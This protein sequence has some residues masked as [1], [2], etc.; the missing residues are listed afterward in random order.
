MDKQADLRK[1]FKEKW[2]DISRKKKGGGHPECGR[3]DANSGGGYPKCRPAR[4]AARMSKKQK[5]YAVRAK[6]SKP[7]G[8]GGKPTMVATF[9]KKAMF[10][11][12][13]DSILESLEV[14]QKEAKEKQLTMFDETKD[15][16]MTR[17][18]K[19]FDKHPGKAALI[20]GGTAGALY[21]LK[22]RRDRKK[23][24]AAEQ[25]GMQKQAFKNP[26]VYDIL[27][28]LDKEA[29]LGRFKGAL[30]GA[31]GRKAYLR[32]VRA[33]AAAGAAGT[34]RRATAQAS[35]EA[36]RAATKAAIP[37]SGV[38]TPVRT[39]RRTAREASALRR[40]R[41]TPDAAAARR[42]SGGRSAAQT[43]TS[44]ATPAAPQASSAPTPRPQPQS[45]TASS[46]PTAVSGVST[47]S[48]PK[49]KAQQVAPTTPKTPAAPKGD[50]PKKPNY[51]NVAKGVAGEAM[52]YAKAK[53]IR[54]AIGVGTALG[55]AN[56]MRRPQT[57][58]QT[59]QPTSSAAGRAVRGA[60]LGAGAV[61]GGSKLLKKVAQDTETIL[62]TLEKEAGRK[63]SAGLAALGAPVGATIGA[64]KGL[65]LGPAGFLG[66]MYAG[67]AAAAGLGAYLGHGR[68]RKHV[69]KTQTNDSGKAKKKK[70]S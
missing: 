19:M 55:A 13:I 25:A 18:G 57:N 41:N 64:I 31:G 8:V 10:N 12:E 61:Y 46:K 58:P 54:T 17:A 43:S 60:A 50:A 9:K 24:E 38:T 40:Q 14:L 65:P 44:A 53:P 37:T 7:Q 68:N 6:R 22:K 32:G 21:A 42:V 15:G 27:E 59:G 63:A 49:P 69:N 33:S 23:R 56:A 26:E 30:A 20:A 48:A 66:G 28:E 3:D 36:R 51:V 11:P 1:W 62:D 2:V 47:S 35:R 5:T 70:V 67:S 45:G 52:D 39:K 34:A 29:F 4:A 16:M